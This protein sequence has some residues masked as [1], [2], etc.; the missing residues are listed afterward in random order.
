MDNRVNIFSFDLDGTLV[1]L[2]F[3]LLVWHEGIPRLFAEKHGLDFDAAYSRVRAEY[4][5]VGDGGLSWYNIRYWFDFFGLSGTYQELF[6]RYRGRIR[7]YP[8]VKKVLESLTGQGYEL[9]LTTNSA[10]EFLTVELEETGLAPFFSKIFSATSDFKMVKKV[11]EF[12]QQIVDML[13]A[14]TEDIVH[15]GDHWK[16]DYLAPRE[17]GIASYF[18]DRDESR[19]HAPEEGIIRSLEELLRIFGK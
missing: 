5:R 12:Y 14:G 1:E 13:G 9:V 17:A 11:P 10:R 4:D 18:I 2:E 15:V 6:Q 16:F 3:N 7:A 19:E 8:E